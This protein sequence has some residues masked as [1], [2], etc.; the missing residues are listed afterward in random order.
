MGLVFP[1]PMSS[2]FTCY[3]PA[4][5]TVLHCTAS[6][7]SVCSSWHREYRSLSILY[8]NLVAIST[9]SAIRSLDSGRAPANLYALPIRVYL[10]AAVV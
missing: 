8:Y 9:I 6:A 7:V 2:Y 10:S 4:K 3:D 5:N 1:N